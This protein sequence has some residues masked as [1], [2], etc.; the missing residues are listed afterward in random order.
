MKKTPKISV[1]PGMVLINT[2]WTHNPGDEI[3]II[4]G[5]LSS[6]YAEVCAI[7]DH[8]VYIFASERTLYIDENTTRGTEVCIDD[9]WIFLEASVAR[10]TFSATVVSKEF[11]ENKIR[12][13][14]YDLRETLWDN[15]DE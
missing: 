14:D 2:I 9:D 7:S 5:D 4:R 10:Y 1:K 13:T 6:K 15:E 8:G 11:Y 3:Q 12:S